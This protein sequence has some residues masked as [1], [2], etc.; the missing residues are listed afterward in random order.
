[1]TPR[2]DERGSA[3][4]LAILATAILGAG[5]MAVLSLSSAERRAVMNQQAQ[6]D[7]YVVAQTGLEQFAANRAALGFTSS[8]AGAYESTRVNVA[9]G[10]ADVV[11]QRLRPVV[12]SEPA[13]YVLRSTGYA[14]SAQLSGTPVAQRQVSQL[15]SWTSGGMSALAAFTG[16]TGITKNNAS[17][18]ISGTDYCG[19]MATVAGVAVPDSPGYSQN[20]NDV[21]SG[22]P[23]ILEFGSKATAAA[24]TG[25]DWTGILA[26][27]AITP[28]VRIPGNSWPSF[29]S[30]SYWPVILVTGDFDLPTDGRGTLIVTGSLNMKNRDWDGI[31]LV[32]D[33]ITINKVSILGT[34]VAGLNVQL[35]GNPPISSIKGNNT[36]RFSSCNI[37]SAS[38][39]PGGLTLTRNAWAD[40]WAGW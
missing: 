36:I 18:T 32:G 17:G 11:L 25:I 21:P 29:G 24:A 34:V 12:G 26:G 38:S 23:D 2:Q 20:G 16:I 14:T 39:G 7:A 30:P 40:N 28:T 22:N 13:V 10:Y 31:I 8:P 1:M 3:L 9:G 35:G 15:A 5:L 33:E 27:T 19:L 4:L 37:A 6:T